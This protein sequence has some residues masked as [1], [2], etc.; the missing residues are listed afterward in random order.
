MGRKL[1]AFGCLVAKWVC[2]MLFDPAIVSS[3]VS[4]SLANQSR[5][6]EQQ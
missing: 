1:I 5:L 4:L 3:N 6:N 2:P